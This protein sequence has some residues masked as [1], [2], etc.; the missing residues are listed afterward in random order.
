MDQSIN[1]PDLEH[2]V[3]P[4]LSEELYSHDSVEGE[5]E[6]EE[7]CDVVDLLR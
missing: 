7:D 3:I 6:E 1:V 4:H 5:E 2:A